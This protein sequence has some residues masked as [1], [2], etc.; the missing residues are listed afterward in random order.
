MQPL[1]GAQ[2]NNFASFDA[3]GGLQDSGCNEGTFIKG[4]QQNGVDLTKDANGKVNVTV[5]DGED[6]ASAYEIWLDENGYTSQDYSEE[7]FLNSLKGE[8][9]SPFPQGAILLQGVIPSDGDQEEK[10]G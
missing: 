1:S 5:Q 10:K 7:D 6:G 9:A 3:N 2:E 4:V 8:T